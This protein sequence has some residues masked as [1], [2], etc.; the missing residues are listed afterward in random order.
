MA[1]HE[2]FSP[3]I[4]QRVAKEVRQLATNPP[5]GIRLLEQDSLAEIHVELRGPEETPYVGGFFEVK[6]LLT[7]GFPTTPPKG[8]FLTKIFH[9]NIASNGDICV[10]TLK[11][12]WSADLDLSHVL[13]VIRCLLIVPFPESSLNDEAGKLFMECYDEYARRAKILTDIHATK[14]KF[15]TDAESTASAAPKRARDDSTDDP[16][17]ARKKKLAKKKG[18]QR[19]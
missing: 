10:N 2:N 17:A 5:E 11:R 3:Q 13:Q 18:L 12:D 8:V 16:A 4:L 15:K 9:P 14:S 7:D 1:A 19:L 6:L